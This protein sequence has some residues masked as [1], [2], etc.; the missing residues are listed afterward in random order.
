MY[1][2]PEPSLAGPAPCPIDTWEDGALAPASTPIA[3]LFVP[4]WFPAPSPIAISLLVF[5]NTN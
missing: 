5:L 1:T 4:P 3:I 2:F